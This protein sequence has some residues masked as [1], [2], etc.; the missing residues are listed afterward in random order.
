MYNANGLVEH[1]FIKQQL[2][3]WHGCHK[4]CY[5]PGEDHPASAALQPAG[6]RR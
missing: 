5:G 1:C 4:T 3:A 2:A 6:R